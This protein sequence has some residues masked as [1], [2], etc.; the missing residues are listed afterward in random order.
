MAMSL[1]QKAANRARRA[2]R[3]GAYRQRLQSFTRALMAADASEEVIQTK[4]SYD[5]AVD[6]LPA[7][8]DRDSYCRALTR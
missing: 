2:V 3:D 7:L 5:E 1:A 6:I 4:R 8:K